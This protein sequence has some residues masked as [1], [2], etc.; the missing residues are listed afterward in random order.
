MH[1]WQKQGYSIL[2]RG[3]DNR[4]ESGGMV[5][6]VQFS[7]YSWIPSKYNLNHYQTLNFALRHTH[8][9]L[10]GFEVRFLTWESAWGVESRRRV[11][12]IREWRRRNVGHIFL[13]KGFTQ[14]TSWLIF[15][16]LEIRTFFSSVCCF[17]FSW[18]ISFGSSWFCPAS[19]LLE[20]FEIVWIK[21]Q[22]KIHYFRALY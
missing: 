5:C 20:W 10:F 4:P 14:I 12:R 15:G 22:F 6:G 3:C 21:N 17:A 18:R 13:H 9:E 1:S 19:R 11:I 16:H 2:K 8:L 7:V